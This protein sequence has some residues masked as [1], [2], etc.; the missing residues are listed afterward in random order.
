MS[1]RRAPRAASI[2]RWIR[3]CAYDRP[4]WCATQQPEEHGAVSISPAPLR[5]HNARRRTVAAS[6]PP[7]GDERQRHPWTLLWAVNTAAVLVARADG[8]VHPAERLGLSA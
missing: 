7:A 5:A 4:A 6:P 3:S 1:D 8:Q 2:C